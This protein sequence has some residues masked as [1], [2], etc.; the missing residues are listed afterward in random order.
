VIS[1]CT[2]FQLA[3]SINL[4]RSLRFMIGTF[5]ALPAPAL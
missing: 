5:L 4:S 3:C 1:P 2:I